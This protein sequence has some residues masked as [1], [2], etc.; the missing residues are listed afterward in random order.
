M[1]YG[2]NKFD[3]KCTPE[4]VKKSTWGFEKVQSQRIASVKHNNGDN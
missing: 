4:K 2:D 3:R 1:E